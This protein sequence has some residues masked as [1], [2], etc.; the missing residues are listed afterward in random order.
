MKNSIFKCFGILKSDVMSLLYHVMNNKNNNIDIQIK[1]NGL[2]LDIIIQSD[3]NNLYFYECVKEVFEKL[4]L[5][6]YAETEISIEEVAL[7]LL[8]INKLKFSTVEILTGGNLISSLFKK[9]KNLCDVVIESLV[10]ISN[11]SKTQRINLTNDNNP[12]KFCSDIAKSLLD[13]SEA[14][15]VIST[16]G[17]GKYGDLDEKDGIAYIAIADK[18]RVD[19]YKNKFVGNKENIIDDI[20]HTALFYLIKKLR[21]NDF[22]LNKNKL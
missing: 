18:M 2:L 8:K 10:L 17:N 5:Y 11:C 19:V 22:Y 20:T 6:I 9:N 3:E 13:N 1:E 16:T 4:N 12:V 15:L 21:K 14:D 7:E